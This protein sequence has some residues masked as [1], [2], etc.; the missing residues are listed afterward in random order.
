MLLVLACSAVH[1]RPVTKARKTEAAGT[2]QQEVTLLLFGIVQFGQALKYVRETTEA[3][4]KRI[5]QTLQRQEE[6]LQTLGTRTERAAEVESG[7]R[8]ALR[9]VQVRKRGGKICRQR[10]SWRWDRATDLQTRRSRRRQE[11]MG[12]TIPIRL[13]V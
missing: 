5:G 8:E 13:D 3:K 7:M 9:R 4:V 1:A 2:P 12:T 6:A 11:E 10:E